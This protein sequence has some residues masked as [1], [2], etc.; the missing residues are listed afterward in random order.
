MTAGLVEVA[1]PCGRPSLHGPRVVEVCQFV[2]PFPVEDRGLAAQAGRVAES[3][4]LQAVLILHVIARE[5]RQ[6]LDRPCGVVE[7]LEDLEGLAAPRQAVER[8]A[9]HGLGDRRVVLQALL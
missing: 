7:I 8:V 5:C 2:H 4:R 1:R 9:H 3:R 6:P